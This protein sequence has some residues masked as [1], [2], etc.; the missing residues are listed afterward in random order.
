LKLQYRFLECIHYMFALARGR[1]L[2]RIERLAKQRRCQFALARGRG[3]KPPVWIRSIGQLSFAL[4]RGRG[5]KPSRS[6]ANAGLQVRPRARAWIE[7]STTALNPGLTV[8][9]LARGRGL[10]PRNWG[11]SEAGSWFALARGRGLKHAPWKW[12]RQTRAF[13]LA[14]GRGLKQSTSAPST[15]TRRSPSREGVD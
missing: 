1:G 7:T 2:K 14:R 12:Q 6:A 3:L 13:A 4:A 15:I 9:A 11:P 5:L 10:K 8:F